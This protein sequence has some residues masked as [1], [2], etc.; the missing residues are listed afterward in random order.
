LNCIPEIQHVKGHQYTD[1]KGKL[2]KAEAL[3]VEADDLM[4][5]ARLLPDIKN[6]TKFPANRGQP[7]SE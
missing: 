3:N 1:K 5:L 7:A 2:T 4:H 6:Y